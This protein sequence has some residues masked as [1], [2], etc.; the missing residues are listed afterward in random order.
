LGWGNS[1]QL[2]Y[3]LGIALGA[4]LGAPE[5][6]VVNIMGD[7]AIGMAGMDIE[8][9]VRHQ[10][11]ILTIVLNNH[12][13]S[14]YAANYPVAADSFA[15]TN[16]Y[17][18]YADLARSLGAYGER[19]EDPA[20]IIPAIGRARAAIANGQPALIEFMTKEE[21]TLSRLPAA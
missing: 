10:I 20:Q 9:G 17:G 3:G 6:L 18:D 8:T 16:L 7:A 21:N 5:K 15:F 19:V 11:P 14:G 12:V 2:G 1:S 4:K 13:L